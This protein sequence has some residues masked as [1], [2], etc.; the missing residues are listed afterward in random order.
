MNLKGNLDSEPVNN[1][2]KSGNKNVNF[3]SAKL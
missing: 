1:L 3:Y 2:S